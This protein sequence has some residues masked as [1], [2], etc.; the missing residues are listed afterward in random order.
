MLIL[1]KK[2]KISPEDEKIITKQFE[3]VHKICTLK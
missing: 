1:G 3:Q 2:Y